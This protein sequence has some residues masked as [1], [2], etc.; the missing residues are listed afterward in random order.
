MGLDDVLYGT[1]RSNLLAA[2]LLP[3]LNKMYAT[4]IQEERMKSMARTKEERG[5]IVGL[6][7][8]TGGRARGR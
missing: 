5:E 1:V 8:Q 2:D 3:S 4:L 7:V 6:A